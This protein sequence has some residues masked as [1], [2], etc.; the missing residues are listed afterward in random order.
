MTVVLVLAP[1]PVALCA[2]P[3]A[4]TNNHPRKLCLRGARCGAVGIHTTDGDELFDSFHS[5]AVGIGM[6]PSRTKLP[7][8]GGVVTVVDLITNHRWVNYNGLLV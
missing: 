2:T 6:F 1:P 8:V 3:P 4:P 7:F 5:W